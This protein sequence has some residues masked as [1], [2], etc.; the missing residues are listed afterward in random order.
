MTRGA[1][2]G[3]KRDVSAIGDKGKIARQIRGVVGVGSM[4]H[5]MWRKL[6]D[7]ALFFFA[8]ILTLVT[9]IGIVSLLICLQSKVHIRNMKLEVNRF[10]K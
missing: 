2:G 8:D 1:R 6:V 7:H 3:A 4:R 5:D 9:C 10:S